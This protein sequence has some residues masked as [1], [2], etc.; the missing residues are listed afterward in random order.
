M[1]KWRERKIVYDQ[2]EM[3]NDTKQVD[4]KEKKIK[5]WTA[6]LNPIEGRRRN[7]YRRF[8]SPKATKINNF[9]KLAIS[10]VI[11]A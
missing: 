8:K 11:F 6:C 1:T 5:S 9:V 10:Y 2:V 7:K 3:T 4:Q